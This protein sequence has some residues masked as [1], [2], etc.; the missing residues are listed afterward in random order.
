MP[1]H[2][3][4]ADPTD[5]HGRTRPGAAPARTGPHLPVDSALVRCPHCDARAVRT[6]RQV[7]CGGCG[8]VRTAGHS[9]HGPVQVVVEGRCGSCG[10]AARREVERPRWPD[11]VRALALRC[12]CGT[13]GSHPVAVY[14]SWWRNQGTD[15]VSGLPLWLRADLRGQVVWALDAEHLAYLEGILGGEPGFRPGS[16]YGTLGSRLPAWIKQARSR[17]DVLQRLRRLRALLADA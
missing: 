17:D 9:F 6:G 12:P 16:R 5:R 15:P 3:I 7:A 8:H 13:L 4:S 10:R 1:Q 2:G 14:P 11:T